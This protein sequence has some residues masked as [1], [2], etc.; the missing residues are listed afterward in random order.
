MQFVDLKQ[1]G[2][3]EHAV[4]SQHLPGQILINTIRPGLF[5]LVMLTVRAHTV[6]IGAR[7]RVKIVG[8]D[9]CP[10]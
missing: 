4:I 6:K 9:E 3:N 5:L 1:I 8:N 7:I 2:S 10:R